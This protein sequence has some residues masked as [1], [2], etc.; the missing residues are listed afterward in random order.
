MEGGG[1]LEFSFC[2]LNV[3]FIEILI[4]LVE[5]RNDGFRIDV[6]LLAAE[7]GFNECG[8]ELLD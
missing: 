1:T 6:F 4:I 5:G 2:E 3:I 7:S 8:L